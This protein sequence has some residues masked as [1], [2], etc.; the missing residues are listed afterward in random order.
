MVAAAVEQ[1]PARLLSRRRRGGPPVLDLPRRCD[2]RWARRA[3]ELVHPRAVRMMHI[4]HEGTKKK[5]ATK[6]ACASS[7]LLFSA[8]CLRVN[9]FFWASALAGARNDA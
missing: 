2:R 4:S 9:P 8:S 6:A 3:S 1:P 5:E 7:C